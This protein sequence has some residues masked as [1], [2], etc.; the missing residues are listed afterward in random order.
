M[1][2]MPS[3]HDTI[4]AGLESD[5]TLRYKLCESDETVLPAEGVL[6]SALLSEKSVL[7]S[8]QLLDF[9]FLSIPVNCLVLLLAF[10]IYQTVF[11]Y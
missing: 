10:L 7:H 1:S 2:L 4:R 8:G 5:C 9:K 11:A 3:S 6:P